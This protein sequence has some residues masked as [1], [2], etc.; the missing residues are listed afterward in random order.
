MKK[1]RYKGIKIGNSQLLLGD[2][3]ILFGMCSMREARK[4]RDILKL[5]LKQ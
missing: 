1:R 5:Y 4:Y 3:V 2:D